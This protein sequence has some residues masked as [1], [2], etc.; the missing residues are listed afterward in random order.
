MKGGNTLDWTTPADYLNQNSEGGAGAAVAK[1]NSFAE[2]LSQFNPGNDATVSQFIVIIKNCLNTGQ[3]NVIEIIH[4]VMK[5]P[6]VQDLLTQLPNATSAISG[7]L[8]AA[9]SASLA[10]P[11]KLSESL[12]RAADFLD[13]IKDIRRDI[14]KAIGFQGLIKLATGTMSISD[15]LRM[16]AKVVETIHETLLKDLA[17]FTK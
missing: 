16:L 13:R 6:K 11:G 12:N 15:G 4:T 2:A 7:S 3:L 8:R 9:V 10:Q 1:L 14:V 17:D 5:E